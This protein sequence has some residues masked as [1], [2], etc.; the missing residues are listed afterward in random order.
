ML[1]NKLIYNCTPIVNNINDSNEYIDCLI[2]TGTGKELAFIQASYQFKLY[3]GKEL[4][5][6]K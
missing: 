5:Y 3:T 6:K 1:N 2:T 4:K